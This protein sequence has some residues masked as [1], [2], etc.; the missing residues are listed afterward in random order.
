MNTSK[1]DSITYYGGYLQLEKRR[2]LHCTL[3]NYI[4]LL[5]YLVLLADPL[6]SLHILLL[7]LVVTSSVSPLETLLSP[8]SIYFRTRADNKGVAPI[9][10]TERTT[11][12]ITFGRPHVQNMH[13]VYL[14]VWMPNMC[15]SFVQNMQ[16]VFLRV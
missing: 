15:V 11:C 12:L 10:K 9:G 1:H 3:Q 6:K 5:V 14:R 7:K 4:Y 13:Y 16:H 8:L 2:G